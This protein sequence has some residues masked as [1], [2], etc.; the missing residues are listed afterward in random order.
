MGEGRPARRLP[1]TRA[2]G[3]SRKSARTSSAQSAAWSVATPPASKTT[4]RVPSR[5]QST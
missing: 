5:S 3:C 2:S 1:I 4:T